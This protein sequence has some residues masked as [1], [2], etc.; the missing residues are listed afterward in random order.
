[1]KAELFCDPSSTELNNTVRGTAHIYKD[2]RVE[3]CV[4]GDGVSVGDFS[5]LADCRLDAGVKLQRNNMLYS[6]EMGRNS[7]TGKNFTA[8][9]CRIGSFCSI[10]WNVSVG[11]ADHDYRRTTTHSMLYSP[12]FGFIED[13]GEVYDRFDKPCV[14]GSDVWI[15]ANACVCRGVTIGDGAVVGAG[16]VVTHDVEPYTIVCGVPAVPLKKR[17]SDEIVE[18]LLKSRWWELPDEVVKENFGLFGAVADIETAR[19]I[20]ALTEE[21]KRSGVL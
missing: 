14:I 17:F 13:G 6:V 8:W 10:S 11:G 19:K 4:L 21:M 7:Y 12:D 15:A 3:N 5:R 9:H 1:M 2:C 18:T 20:L 16:A